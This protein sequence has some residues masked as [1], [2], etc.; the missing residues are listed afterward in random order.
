MIKTYVILIALFLGLYIYSGVRG[1]YF[2]HMLTGQ[3]WS[4][5]H[6]SPYNHK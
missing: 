5:S 2:P 4:R 1:I 3:A 6:S